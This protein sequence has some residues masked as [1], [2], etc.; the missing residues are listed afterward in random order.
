MQIVN[1]P[2][3]VTIC[4]KSYPIS[5]LHNIVKRQIQEITSNNNNIEEI[6]KKVHNRKEEK[7]QNIEM[8][9]HQEESSILYERKQG[10]I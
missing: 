5:T 3:Q 7:N 6:N 10:K 1:K 9:V 4:T 2:Q 8:K